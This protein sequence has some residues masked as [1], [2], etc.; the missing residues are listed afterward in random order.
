MIWNWR[1]RKYYTWRLAQNEG[2]NGNGRKLR[3][4]KV[5]SNNYI[6]LNRLNFL[7]DFVFKSPNRH[8]KQLIFCICVTT[9]SDVGRKKRVSGIHREYVL[10]FVVKLTC[11]FGAQAHFSEWVRDRQILLTE[12]RKI[13]K[14]IEQKTEN[15]TKG[16]F[17]SF[18]SPA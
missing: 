2:E 5:F 16:T 1:N 7:F 15:G 12:I 8:E 10:Y 17:A 9:C 13:E 4:K 3:G 18:L 6:S 11:I 14:R